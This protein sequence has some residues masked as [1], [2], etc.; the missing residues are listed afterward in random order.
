MG[1]SAKADPHPLALWIVVFHIGLPANIQS[2]LVCLIRQ[3]CSDQ[4]QIAMT[5]LAGGV[6]EGDFF[7]YLGQEP[8]RVLG[9][10]TRVFQAFEMGLR[11][12]LRET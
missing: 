2:L 3:V 5:H 7:D 9:N 12:I 8:L 4:N 10:E 6:R 11:Q 1:D